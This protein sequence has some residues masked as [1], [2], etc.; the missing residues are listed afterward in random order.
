[1]GLGLPLFLGVMLLVGYR[2]DARKLH[3][4]LKTFAPPV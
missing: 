1:M 3:G 4:Y 2:K